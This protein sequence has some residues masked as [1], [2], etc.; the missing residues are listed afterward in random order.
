MGRPIGATAAAAG[1]GLIAAALVGAPAHASTDGTGVVI[2]EAYL[3]GGSAGAAYTNKFVELYNPGPADIDVSGWSL[4]Y[5]SASGTG[6]ATGVT[7]LTGTIDSGGYLLVAGGSNG[8]SGVALPTPDVA[9]S[10]NPSGTRGTIVLADTSSALTLPT[11]SITPETPGVIDVLGYGTSNTF[12]GAPA[13]APSSNTDV[14]SLVRAD[15]A[16]TDSN[17]ADF[18]LTATITPEN[19]AGEIGEPG[20]GDPGDGDPGDGDPGDGPAPTLSIAEIQ[21]TSDTSPVAGTTVTTRGVVTAAYPTGGFSGYYIQTPGTGGALQLAQHTASDGLF[22]FSS[23]TVSRVAIGDY[24]QVTGQVS[25]YYGLTELSVPSPAGLVSLDAGSVAAPQPATV[26]YPRSDAERESL[27]GML[28]APQGSF[29]VSDTYST[30]Q[31]GEVG[32]AAGDVALEQPTEVARP[33]SAEYDAV[34][35]DNAARAVTLDDGASTNFLSAAN[36]SKPLPYVSNDHPVRVSAPATFVRPVVLD[37]RNSAWKFQPTTE[38]TPANASDVQPARFDNTRTAKPQNVGG[39]VRLAT[40][41]VLNYF[42]TTGDQ[43]E[44]CTFYTDR[45]GNPITVKSGCDARGAANDANFQRQQAKIVAAINALGADVVSL[46]EIENS[47]KFGK[48]RDDAVG[49]LVAALNKAAGHRVWAY[50]PSPSALP[51]VQDVIRTAFIYKPATVKLAGPSQILDD[52]AFDNARQPLAQAFQL[53]KG[54]AS[55]RFIAIV[56]HFKSKGSGSGA[57]ADQGDGQGASNASRVKQANALVDFAAALK[58]S[59]KSDRVLLVGDF[60]SY[61][62]EDPIVAITGAGYSD[63]GSRTAKKTYAYDGMVGSLD[64]VLAS[65]GAAKAIT[66]VDIWNINSGESVALEYSRYNYNV[67]DFYRPDPYRSSDHDP[68]VVGLRLA[69]GNGHGH[70][71]PGNG[72]VNPGH[73]HGAP[74]PGHGGGCHGFRPF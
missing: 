20:D 66:G 63:Q 53:K 65:P 21:G 5:R 11:G 71:H 7:A 41:N 40:F 64:H 34:V 8:D 1:L 46:E 57:D 24:V 22:V 33:G 52:T 44:G 39:D 61:L 43:L 74:W 58:R 19:S 17:A 38:L 62:M 28:I 3:S 9:G 25:E 51:A 23:A 72:H 47:V 48:D 12:E 35:A 45:D 31:Y 13:Q 27:E 55:T 50:A 16:D 2:N 69:P 67:T 18:S 15:F 68:V 10:L 32:L 49:R 26:A 54:G 73:G 42:P 30:N 59:M 29:T 4:Q 56:N 60:N 36:Q 70:G 37:Y 14:R 6:A